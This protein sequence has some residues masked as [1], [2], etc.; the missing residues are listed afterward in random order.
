M[1]NTL[2]ILTIQRVEFLSSFFSYL[3]CSCI[4]PRIPRLA[5]SCIQEHGQPR[6][7]VNPSTREAR[8]TMILVLYLSLYASVFY[9][10]AIKLI[11]V[12]PPMLVQACFYSEACQ[13]TN[14]RAYILIINISSGNVTIAKKKNPPDLLL[15][16]PGTEC[17]TSQLGLPSRAQWVFAC[18]SI[19]SWT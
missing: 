17:S 8:A 16:A 1:Y 6:Q 2:R 18:I 15:L 19:R 9:S 13:L 4:I 10:R 3:P 5:W 11:M 14:S 12:S 7:F